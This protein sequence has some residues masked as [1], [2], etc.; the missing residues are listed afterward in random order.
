M[1]KA[2]SDNAQ[3]RDRRI[4][5]AGDR[6]RVAIDFSKKADD[7]ENERQALLNERAEIEVW[8]QKVKA[9][10]AKVKAGA[11]NGRSKMNPNV[12]AKWEAERSRKLE[13]KAFVEARLNA[14]KVERNNLNIRERAKLS[15][16]DAFF[17]CAKDI[18]PAEVMDLINSATVALLAHLD[19]THL[20]A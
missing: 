8:L 5:L 18:L 20:S 4:A 2:A 10:K 11:W 12:F 1:Y 13:R 14:I 6:E 17:R 19:D 15:Y 7:L 3:A 16:T 9:D